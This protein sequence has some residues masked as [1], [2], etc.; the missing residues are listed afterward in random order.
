MHGRGVFTW[1][2]GRRYDGD[3][4]DDRKQ[5]F[6]VFTWPDGRRYEG[7]WLNGKQ[8][9]IGMYHTSKGEAKKGEWSEGKRLRWISNNQNGNTT[10][11]ARN[12]SP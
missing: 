7:S 12:E 8:H 1:A 3:Y 11:G 2:D 10:G 6:G 9:G 5:G 4:F